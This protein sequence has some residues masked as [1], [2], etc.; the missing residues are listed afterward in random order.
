MPTP[1]RNAAKIQILRQQGVLNPHPEAVTDPLFQT[2]AFFDPLDLL[3]VKYEMLRRVE[4]DKAPVTEAAAAFGVSRPAFYQAQNAVAQQGLA[5]LIP[6]KR[7]PH[8][9]HKLTPAVLDFVLQQRAAS[10]S[11][12][13]AELITRIQQQFG[14]AVHR[15]TIER[16]LGRQEKKRR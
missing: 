15:R 7:G 9:A 6:R 10:P 1:R 13:I 8:G 3:Q 5:G 11:L 2:G 12:T 4:V 14:V 16:H